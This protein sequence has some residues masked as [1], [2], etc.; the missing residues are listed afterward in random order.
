M[1][2]LFT[3]VASCGEETTIS[4]PRAESQPRMVILGIDGL[5]PEILQE[6]MD[7]FPERM[8]NF[9]ALASEGAGVIPLQTST[10]PQS[11]V[12]WSC[13][14]TGRNPGGH[15]IYDF[16]HR[17][18]AN[19][20]E[21]PGTRTVG[22]EDSVGLPGPWKF[23]LSEP[24][25]SNRSGKA[26][27]T[28]M[29]E[30]GVPASIWR[31]PINFPAEPA[32]GS[33]FSGMLTPAVDSAYG[34]PTL[35]TTLPPIAR[36][37]DSKVKRIQVRNG[38]VR[39]Q[40]SGPTNPFRDDDPK[41]EVPMDLYV[42]MEAGALALSLQGQNIV[43]EP[44]QWSDFVG[45][46]FGLLPMGTSNVS[47]I[48]R[49]YLRSLEPE[50]ELYASPV[51]IDPRKP[52]QPV[53]SPAN[54]SAELADAIGLY[55]TQGMAE[56]VNGLKKGLLTDQ[57]FAAQAELVFQER[58]RMLDFALDQYMD[59]EN[60][61]L[62]FFYY[63][64]VD[65]CGHMLWRLTDQD[66]PNYDARLSAE[67]SEWWSQRPG[68]RWNDALMDLYMKMDGVLGEVRER[69]G[70]ET[71][72]MVMSD[73]GF[74]PYH[75]IFSLNA[76]LVQEGYLVLKEGQASEL[77]PDQ[78]DFQPVTLA[79]AVDWSRSRAYGMGFNGLYLN[80]NGRE[81]EGLVEPGVEA[82]ALLAEIKAGLEALRDDAPE[83]RGTRIVLAAD[84]AA[85][86]FSGDR[87][88]EAPD[89][90]VGYNS[91]YGNSDESSLGRIPYAVLRDNLGGTFNGN[92]LMHPSVVAGTLLTNGV[93]N[94]T[95]IRLEDVTAEILSQYHVTPAG[96]LDGSPFLK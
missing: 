51:N 86:V 4:K 36:L 55:Y 87:L 2:V 35:F 1:C 75:R 90:L 25:D 5:D 7:R 30:Q 33:S 93:L 47:G 16:I 60:G 15:G 9:R 96:E 67:S 8:A 39:T 53:S 89:L 54:A 92:H 76:W 18:P 21:T 26:F 22:E 23:P 59:E 57:E 13:F 82:Q 29:G 19:Y 20:R 3:C 14:I 94:R 56:D 41:S 52:I 64:T 77:P 46:N 44:G 81:A 80:L 27:W 37:S 40:L 43:L 58:N 10:P 11:P 79:Q 83:R 12:A 50:L 74:A 42:D 24:G 32:L 48:V 71:L 6:A 31:M 66:H 63:S 17:N 68:S 62:L 38:R 65:L 91:G 88:S 61:G 85:A 84:F 34:Q 28:V 45:V 49:F 69:V 70:P 78:P 95:D 72:I 73:H